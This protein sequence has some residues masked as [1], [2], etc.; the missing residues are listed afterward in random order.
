MPAI[1][2]LIG[3]LLVLVG[4]GGF[5]YSYAKDGVAHFTALIPAIIGVLILLCGALAIFKENLRKHMMHGA[6]LVALLG[7]LGTVMG[8]VKL[9]TLIAGG[10]IERP[11]A[12]VSQSL[13]AVLCLAFILIGVWSFIAARRSRPAEAAEAETV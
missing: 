4:L 13:T 6:L 9:I 10:S 11:L 2:I 8:V 1:T 5:G 7:F 3:L 12:V